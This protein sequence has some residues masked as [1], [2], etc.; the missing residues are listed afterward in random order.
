MT[1]IY[2]L[3]SSKIQDLCK[4]LKDNK[5]WVYC[6]Y[7]G[8]KNNPND[9]D[10]PEIY[11]RLSIQ[12]HGMLEFHRYPYDPVTNGLRPRIE[13]VPNNN[14]LPKNVPLKISYKVS[15]VKGGD[16]MRGMIFQIM[17]KTP[18][19]KTLPVTQF[20]VRNSI[21]YSRWTEI[22][23]DGQSLGTRIMAMGR[24]IFDENYVYKLTMLITLSSD[25]NKGNIKTFIDD[26][27][28]LDINTITA[29]SNPLDSQV[30]FGIYCVDNVDIITRVK[31]LKITRQI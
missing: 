14:R 7:T 16:K 10:D 3:E 21:L 8:S 9:R 25:K 17:D 18:D 5:I 29:S 13:L 30:Q 2:H 22:S 12:A 15:L 31:E 4:Y 19:A 20:E 26:R 11:K 28:V 6:N 1:I 24:A 27:L 23:K